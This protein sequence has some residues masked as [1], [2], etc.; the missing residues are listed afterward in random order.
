MF[1][2]IPE[3]NMDIVNDVYHS[4]NNFKWAKDGK[5]F[6]LEQRG[7]TVHIGCYEGEVF[8]GVFSLRELPND[9]FEIHLGLLPSIWGRS[10]DLA[11]EFLSQLGK[12]IPGAKLVAWVD[13][14]NALAK[15]LV[16][17]VGFVGRGYNIY[18]KEL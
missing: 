17:K 10:K 13:P 11:D 6:M 2:F 18:C 14:S 7:D 15:S 16:R 3:P 5:E 9:E 4:K 1:T 12:I 8:H